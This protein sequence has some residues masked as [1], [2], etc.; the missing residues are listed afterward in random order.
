METHQPASLWRNADFMKLW[1][2]QTVS[3][4]GSAISRLAIPLIAATTL[5][6]TP[7]EMGLLTALGTAPSLLI[8]LFA[9]VWVDRFRRR[10]LLISGDFGRAILL[11]TIPIAAFLGRLS[12][13]QIFIVSFLHGTL[14][15][16][17]NVA[18]RSFLPTVIDRTSLVEGNS[19]L[20]ISGS[21][22]AVAGPS[23]AG[24]VIQAITAPVAIILDV[25][26]YLVSAVCVIL[27]RRPEQALQVLRERTIIQIRDGLGIVLHSS[28]LRA[29]AGCLATSNFFSNAFFA[30]YIL[31]GTRDLQLNAA[32]LGLVY[33]LGASGALVAAVAAPR[34]TARLGVGKATI[35][36]ALLGSLEVLPVVFATPVTGIPL[37]LLSSFLGNF[38]WVLYN[39]NAVSMRQALTPMPLQGRMN[40]TF[41]FLESGMLPLGALAGGVLGE[42]LGLRMT[43]ALA[44]FGSLLSVLWILFSPVK[45]MEHVPVNS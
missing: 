15:L 4:I 17:F 10:A 39:V 14:S 1:S 31:F 29:F 44:A 20:E 2:G 21:I 9:G 32:D 41:S 38:G 28:V 34:L 6:A 8:G 18:S 7:A 12:M 24:L 37:L 11:L 33:G 16:I 27:I 26:S 43:I 25:A 45:G 36:G 22:T 35:L 5:N 19:K 42:L 3:W 40:A 30:L 23:L 13:L